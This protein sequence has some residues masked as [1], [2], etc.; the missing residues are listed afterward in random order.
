MVLI[1]MRSAR[2]CFKLQAIGLQLRMLCCWNPPSAV[3]ILWMF[4]MVREVG[5]TAA[6]SISVLASLSDE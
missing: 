6:N 4:G 3:R 2:L 5:S 1:R